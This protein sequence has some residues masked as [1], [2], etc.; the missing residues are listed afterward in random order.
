[1]RCYVDQRYGMVAVLWTDI[2]CA[3]VGHFTI[4]PDQRETDTKPD[5]RVTNRIGAFLDGDAIFTPQKDHACR[6]VV[7]EIPVRFHVHKAGVEGLEDMGWNG[8]HL[9]RGKYLLEYS[10]V[11]SA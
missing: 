9:T 5:S 11:M 4:G 10:L 8:P 7:P 3:N 6:F 1:M 2:H